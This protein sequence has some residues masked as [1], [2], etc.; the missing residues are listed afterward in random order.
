MSPIDIQVEGVN[1]DLDGG[2]LNDE[3]EDNGDYAFDNM[4]LGGNYT[5]IPNKDGDDLSWLLQP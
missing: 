4:P 2:E 3:T 5:V 1:V